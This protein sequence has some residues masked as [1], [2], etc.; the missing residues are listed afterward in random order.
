MAERPDN[1]IQVERTAE[2]G[3]ATRNL[4][5]QLDLRDGGAR[6]SSLPEN[7]C[8]PTLRLRDDRYDTCDFYSSDSSSAQVF[9]KN[10]PA[11]VRINTLDPRADAKAGTTAG[12]GFIIDKDGL[13]ATG[14]HVIRNATSIRV[15]MADNKVYEA[16]LVAVDAQKDQALLQISANNPFEQFPTVKLAS[17]SSSVRSDAKLIALGFP[18]NSDNLH[19]SELQTAGTIKL[20]DV[21][22][23]EGVMTG[24]DASRPVFKTIGNVMKGN[25]GG[26]AF[27]SSGEVIGTVNLSNQVQTYIT[28]IEELK[29]MRDVYRSGSNRYSPT[30]AVTLD[31][32]IKSANPLAAGTAGTAGVSRYS[33]PFV[34]Q[35][36]MSAPTGI[37][38]ETNTP[39]AYRNLLEFGVPLKRY[40]SSIQ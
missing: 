4:L 8:L 22:L 38:S 20:K 25:S 11:L 1:S 3:G 6:A 36:R 32:I 39:A 30:L 37:P 18:R 10:K 27:N 15:K 26:P 31:S 34:G 13:I 29:Q 16:K 7:L 35:F 17:D 33:N 24:E 14:Y 23:K 5:A 12:S 40:G 2:Y 28:P 9:L 19:V 21:P